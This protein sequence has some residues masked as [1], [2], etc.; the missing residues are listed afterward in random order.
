M[1]SA[2]A[3]NNGKHHESGA[4]YGLNIPRADRDRFFRRERGTVQL[5]I[6]G[7]IPAALFDD[8]FGRRAPT[9]EAMRSGIHTHEFVADTTTCF[10]AGLRGVPDTDFLRDGRQEK[11]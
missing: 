8:R 5:R 3:W 7:V 10:E 4:G 6:P 2:S 1:I 9:R 11:A